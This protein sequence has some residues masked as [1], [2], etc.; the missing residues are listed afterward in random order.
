VRPH[1]LEEIPGVRKYSRT[2]QPLKEELF[3]KHIQGIS[4]KQLAE[5]LAMGSASCERYVQEMFS[6]K[7]RERLG[8]P[9]PRGAGH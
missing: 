4:Q 6:L 3:S 1:V 8:T 5:D 7:Y 2:S 9:W